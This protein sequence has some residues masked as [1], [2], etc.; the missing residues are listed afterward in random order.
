MQHVVLGESGYTLKIIRTRQGK[1]DLIVVY[2]VAIRERILSE[3]TRRAQYF[4]GIHGYR[5]HDPGVERHRARWLGHGIPSAEID[6][7]V[8][9]QEV[10]GGIALPPSPHYDGGPRSFSAD[11][12]E[13]SEAKGWWFEAW[14]QHTALPYA[15][16][17]GPDGAFGIHAGSWVPLH[18]SVEGRVESVALADHACGCART[19]TTVTGEA[20]EALQ[21]DG[22]EPVL[23]VAGR[24]DTWRRGA[25]SLVAVYRGEA[26]CMSAPR[27]RTATVYSGLDEW[28]LEGIGV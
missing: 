17:I 6:R 7:A 20:V 16:M 12:P 11:V 28:D 21:L 18:G 10:W 22:F 2:R 27:C 1:A 19:I 24:A 26:E 15:F 4:I 14:L 5:I 9:Y 25:D 13:G 8:A 23:E 3:L